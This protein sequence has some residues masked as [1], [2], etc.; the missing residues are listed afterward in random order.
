[1]VEN[2]PAFMFNIDTVNK[3]EVGK[4]MLPDHY[5]TTGHI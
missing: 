3:Y 2:L 4:F 1:M 5:M